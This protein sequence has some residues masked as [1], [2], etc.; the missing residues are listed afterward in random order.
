MQYDSIAESSNRGFLQYYC[1]AIK[2]PPVKKSTIIRFFLVLLLGFERFYCVSIHQYLQIKNMQL[3]HKSAYSN[4]FPRGYFIT[5][6]MEHSCNLAIPFSQ[7]P[8]FIIGEG[9]ERVWKGQY[10]DTNTYNP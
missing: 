6:D 2:Q 3:F 1:A 10:G 9:I 8:A 5:K 7:L 4:L